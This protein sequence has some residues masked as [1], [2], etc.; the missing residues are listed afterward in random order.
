[1]IATEG[2]SAFT[3]KEGDNIVMHH[4]QIQAN[5]RAA[6]AALLLGLVPTG[7]IGP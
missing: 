4:S 2:Y 5:C 6:R 1:M 3:I 7:V